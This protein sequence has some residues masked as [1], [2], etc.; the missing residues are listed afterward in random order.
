M[1]SC[2]NI[3]ILSYSQAIRFQNYIFG[4]FVYLTVFSI[5][6]DR[7]LSR[8]FMAFEKAQK[9]NFDHNTIIATFHIKKCLYE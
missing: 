8:I 7:F 1:C 2:Q 3:P 6:T 5:H 4:I 9:P